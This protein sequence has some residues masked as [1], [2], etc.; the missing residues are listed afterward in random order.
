M[1]FFSGSRGLKPPCQLSE[2]VETMVFSF[3]LVFSTQF[4]VS[5]THVLVSNPPAEKMSGA[6][7]ARKLG[8]RKS[9]PWKLDLVS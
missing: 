9:F 6:E 3:Q 5:S 2:R 1:F 8:A 4:L 7:A